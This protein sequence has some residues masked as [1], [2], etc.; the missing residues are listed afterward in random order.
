MEKI[1]ELPQKMLPSFD[2][3]ITFHWVAYKEVTNSQGTFKISWRNEDH[4]EPSD[5]V[6][7]NSEGVIIWVIDNPSGVLTKYPD[8]TKRFIKTE[9]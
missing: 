8:G 4:W 6:A 5:S 7:I 2:D 1:N 9:L 3:I